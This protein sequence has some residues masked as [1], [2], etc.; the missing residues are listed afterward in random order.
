[1]KITYRTHD[2]PSIGDYI[3]S[4]RKPRRAYFIVGVRRG[5][6]MLNGAVVYKLTVEPLKADAV[7]A[8]AIVLPI[9]WDLRTRRRVA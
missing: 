5:R 9:F 6:E 8:G 1:M 4:T 2:T 7:P 3:R